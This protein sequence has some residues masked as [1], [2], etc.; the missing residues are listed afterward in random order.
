MSTEPKDNHKTM[1]LVYEM[2]VMLKKN[3]R[4][5]LFFN[6]TFLIMGQWKDPSP[7]Q[8]LV[9]RLLQRGRATIYFDINETINY[10]LFLDDCHPDLFRAAETATT[11]HPL[12]PPLVSIHW[13]LESWNAEKLLP[14]DDYR[15]QIRE[16]TKQMKTSEN[17]IIIPTKERM[18]LTIFRGSLFALIRIAP[19]KD[20]LDFDSKALTQDIVTHGGQMITDEVIMALRA[21]QYRN[22][23]QR[24]RICFAVVWGGFTQTHISMHTM[25][26]QIQKENLCEMKLV[27]PIW[28]KSCISEKRL[29]GSIHK[30][31][32][33]FQPQSWPMYV[34]SPDIKI[35]V[36]GYV[37]TER[38]AL[39]ELIRSVGACYTEAMRPNNTHL[40]CKTANGQKYEKAIE[41]KIHIVSQEW[42]FHVIRFGIRSEV[43]CEARFSL[44]SLMMA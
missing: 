31:P 25:L 30:H 36:S 8:V 29:L 21:D 7:E 44:L 19:P 13:I 15:P 18:S 1:S 16:Q 43:G 32:I 10:I 5:K 17:K 9:E 3:P 26:S 24:C 35:S 2:E 38:T 42:L 37:G 34:L 41:W 22:D 40:I 6:C 4:S 33:F 12:N 20:A 28:L 14:A 27:S 11:H 39:V 23:H